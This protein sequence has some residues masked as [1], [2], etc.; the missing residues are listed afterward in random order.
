MNNYF[1]YYISF[2]NTLINK[3][4]CRKQVNIYFLTLGRH[5]HHNVFADRRNTC[6]LE[7]IVTVKQLQKWT[8][9]DSRNGVISFFFRF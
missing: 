7:A 3:K 8:R 5:K 6:S 9:M 1:S 4:L 2:L